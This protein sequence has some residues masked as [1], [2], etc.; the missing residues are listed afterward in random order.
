[1]K[2]PARTLIGEIERVVSALPDAVLFRG[3]APD[4]LARF[5]SVMAMAPPPG[6]AAFLAAHDGGLLGPETRLLTM[7]EAVARVSGARR[8]PG[9]SHWPAGLWPIVDRAGRRYALD[10]EEASGDGEWPVVEVTEQGVDR[11]GTSCLRFLHVLC[12][13]LAATG[14]PGES[15][16]AL[17]E[18]RC[19]RDPGLADHWLDFAEL[20]EPEGRAAEIDATLA[21]ALRAATPPTP[22]LMLAIGMRAVRAGDQ[23]G[24]LRAFSDAIALEPIGARDDDARLDA[25]ALVSVLAAERG[26]PAAVAAARALLGEATVATAAFWRGEALAALAEPSEGEVGGKK[27]FDGPISNV[28]AL[29]VRIVSA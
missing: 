20:L 12:A 22:A 19:H 1:M 8:T 7:D 25:A 26:D 2:E 29:A 6:L 9:I 15:A 24:A 5:Q 17:C 11:V 27:S 21:A 10:A 23:D 18:A 4:G 14:V 3:A 16:I 13:E 28:G